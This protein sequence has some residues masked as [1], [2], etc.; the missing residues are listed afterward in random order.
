VST[1]WSLYVVPDHWTLR[2]CMTIGYMTRC[3]LMVSDDELADL[4][5]SERESWTK[6]YDEL[7][8]Q[9]HIYGFTSDDCGNSECEKILD[10]V[11][12]IGRLYPFG[13]ETYELFPQLQ[14]FVGE[15]Y[16]KRFMCLN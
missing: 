11:G 5:K 14:Q 8:N 16:G 10:A 2:D 13:K 12:L 7:L 6:L 9:P 4:M 15:H 1:T 3:S